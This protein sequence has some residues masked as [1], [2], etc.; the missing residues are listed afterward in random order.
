MTTR[1]AIHA[2]HGWPV[3]VVTVDR[4]PDGTVSRSTIRVPP[5]AS[6]DVYPHA[7]RDVEIHEIQPGEPDFPE[8]AAAAA[9]AESEAA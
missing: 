7:S 6:L 3:R 8:P 5:G 2:N 1:V 9:I 4:L